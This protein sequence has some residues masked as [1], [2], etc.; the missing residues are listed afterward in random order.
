LPEQQAL[1]RAYARKLL[2]VEIAAATFSRGYP[3]DHEPLLNYVR[4]TINRRVFCMH[5]IAASMDEEPVTPSYLV[6]QLGMSRNAVDTMIQECES[7]NWIIVDRD[8][9]DHRTM[10][11]TDFMVEVYMDYA[12]WISATSQELG[13]SD[14]QAAVRLLKT[15]TK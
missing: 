11:S 9:R 14:I 2:I 15:M 3:T 8:E 12:S 7:N 4:S 5:C 13:L 1:V 6:N 10:Y